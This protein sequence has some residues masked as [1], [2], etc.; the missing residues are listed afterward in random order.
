MLK[1]TLPFVDLRGKTPVDLLRAYPDKSRAIIDAVRKMYGIFSYAGSAV[2]MPLADWRSK[3]LLIRGRSPYLHEVE[4]MADVLDRRGIFF[5]N[6]CYEW[7]CTSGAWRHDD[8]VSMLRVLDWPFP[9]LGRHA[10][11]TCQ[12]G[13]AGIYYNVTWPGMSGVYNGMAPGRFCIA[14]NQ[15]PMRGHKLTFAGDWLKNRLD[16]SQGKG[17]PPSHLVRM[18]FETATD[19][20]QAKAVL[21]KTP[22]AVPA[23]FIVSGLYPGEGCVIERLENAAEVRELSAGIQV[24]TS[25]H[26]NTHFAK[27]GESWWPREIDSAGRYRQALTIGS[28]DLEQPNFEWLHAPIINANTRLALVCNAATGTFMVQ[29]FEGPATVT[30]LFK[31]PPLA[32]ESAQAI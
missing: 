28:H 20:A 1:E 12:Q 29:G 16:S 27:V 19:Y 15:A 8:G 9:N 30:N 22:L 17:I 32:Y 11:V 23:I 10:I 14:I 4:T 26:F 24:C 13:P 3:K 7:A 18:V 5:L 25:N 2:L 21:Q 31:L 6:M